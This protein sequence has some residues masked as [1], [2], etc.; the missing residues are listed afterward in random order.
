MGLQESINVSI[1][2]YSAYFTN[3]CNLRNFDL[4][5]SYYTIA[6][7]FIPYQNFYIVNA[8]SNDIYKSIVLS[9]MYQQALIARDYQ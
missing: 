5:K 9:N 6:G 2:S 3:C 7:T 4:L 8:D 1:S